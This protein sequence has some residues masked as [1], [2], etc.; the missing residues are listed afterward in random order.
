MFY[1][2]Y[3]EIGGGV[4]KVR[5]RYP[6]F[7]IHY[8]GSN[9]NKEIKALQ[10][11]ILAD[12]YDDEINGLDTFS[13]G[14]D[15]VYGFEMNLQGGDHQHMIYIPGWKIK[16]YWQDDST[17]EWLTTSNDIIEI[18]VEESDEHQH[19]IRIWRN[20]DNNDEW[21]YYL[22]ACRYGT[23]YGD[24]GSWADGECGDGHDTLSRY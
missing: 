1:V 6:I 24:S 16:E 18:E 9:E 22:K 14:T 23:E 15:L 5:Q 7:P 17:K 21:V 10:E 13:N 8:G 3:L 20:K 4:G 19:V 2:E 11:I 12:D